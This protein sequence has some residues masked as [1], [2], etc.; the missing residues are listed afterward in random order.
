MKL[1]CSNLRLAPIA[2]ALGLAG[3]MNIGLAEDY[4]LNGGLY[5]LN[6][7]GVDGTYISKG[8][9]YNLNNSV[10]Q[11]EGSSV[12]LQWSKGKVL[13]NFTQELDKIIFSDGKGSKLNLRNNDSNSV[14][15]K[16]NEI[17]VDTGVNDPKN[18]W[19]LISIN[20]GGD[21]GYNGLI[22]EEVNI[23]DKN[24]L[25]LAPSNESSHYEFK[26][27]NLGNDS[28]FSVRVDT[29][30]EDRL[31]ITNL[32]LDN[33]TVSSWGVDIKEEWENPYLEIERASLMG[34]SRSDIPLKNT[35][36]FTAE[37]ELGLYHFDKKEGHSATIINTGE[38]YIGKN[39]Y[40]A[41]SSRSSDEFNTFKLPTYIGEA[42][43]KLHFGVELMEGGDYD[44]LI[45]TERAEGE[46]KVVIH[47]VSEKVTDSY[48][49]LTLV[50]FEDG[51]E[52]NLEL[53]LENAV[54]DGVYNYNMVKR[55]NN[56]LLSNELPELS[57]LPNET[58]T[59]RKDY[60]TQSSAYLATQV[61]SNNMFKHRYHDRLYIPNSDGLWTSV[62]GSFGKFKS[63]LTDDISTKTNSVTMYIGK[64]LV[65]TNEYT[66]GLMTAYGHASGKTENNNTLSTAEKTDYRSHGFA[67]GV[68]GTYTFAPHS[69][70]DAWAQYV[71]TRNKLEWGGNSE[72][73]NAKGVVLSV[74]VARAFS[75]AESVY[76][77][78]QGQVTYM[79]VKADDLKL[80]NYTYSSDRGNVQ[81]RLGG[82][83]FGENVFANGKGSP[84]IEANY[85]HNTKSYKTTANSR[86]GS[87]DLDIDGAKNLF[88]LKVGSEFNLNNNS[89]IGAHVSHTFGKKSYRD[90]QLNVDFRY[91]F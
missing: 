24:H 83:F 63:S 22:V 56:W 7:Q 21:R 3:I 8:E 46:S 50:R 49:A 38:M 62:T 20:G 37:G 75:I 59:D 18:S 13:N 39:R 90:T 53:T 4:T 85:I 89:K 42:G 74:E 32:N 2:L 69:Y 73:Y 31:K 61:I 86:S 33:A 12:T 48:N 1:K 25:L 15:V 19:A 76:F 14:T 78:P 64:D 71:H 54:T 88:Q 81:F 60:A 26:N 58:G 80:Y 45:I 91:N 34:K 87:V 10:L 70:V 51:A 43:S 79:G 23:K 82:R 41:T 65:S 44:Q 36:I 16:A 40:R 47:K 9:E 35:G 67:V 11:L 29:I 6:Y 27:L 84:F 55:D 28:I 68:Y 72:K 52:N 77:Q 66:I 30:S 5:T 17:V 57:E